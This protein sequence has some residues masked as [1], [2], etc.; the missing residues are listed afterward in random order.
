MMH[1]WKGRVIVKVGVVVDAFHCWSARAIQR[2]LTQ[3]S[4]PDSAAGAAFAVK[5]LDMTR[6]C[7]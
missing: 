6:A 7:L 1:S 5:Q 3:I 2:E 4:C